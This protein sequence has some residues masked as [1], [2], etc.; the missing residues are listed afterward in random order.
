MMDF[1]KAWY[2]NEYGGSFVWG[3][4]ST[5]LSVV[6][7]PD[8]DPINTLCGELEK[9][10]FGAIG[11]VD[12]IL[13]RAEPCDTCQ[14]LT[15]ANCQE[16]SI[17][18]PEYFPGGLVTYTIVDHQSG[19]EYTQSSETGTWNLSNSAGIFTPFSV[20]TLTITDENGQP[21]SWTVGDIEYTC[22]RITFVN[23][24]DTNVVT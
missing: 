2:E 6:F 8:T 1:I 14:E 24:I 23:S 22:A 13:T 7:R 3:Y 10:S 5:T 11:L 19:V 4:S 16:E 17:T 18:F 21:V 12:L 9:I 15:F 20:Y